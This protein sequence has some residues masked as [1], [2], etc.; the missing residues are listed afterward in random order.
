MVSGSV[1]AGMRINE[2][3]KENIKPEISFEANE[4]NKTIT[5]KVTHIRGIKN[6]TYRWN[7]EEAKEIETKN[8]NNATETINMLGGENTLSV[9]ATDENGK[10]QTLE[11]SYKVENIPEIESIES[12]DNGVKITI[13]SEEKLD[14]LQYSWDDG[15]MQKIEIGEK[16]YEGII[17][18]PKGKHTLKIEVV[19][20]KG[21]KADIVK[22][23]IGDTVP[24]V[25]VES[26]YIDG[27]PTFVIDAEDDESITT[28]SIIHNGGE[29][30]VINVNEK[31]FHKEVQ[32]TENQ[33]NTI[34]IT[35]TNK[36]GLEQTRRI[37]IKNN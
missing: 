18:A 8:R 17:N 27:K 4:E 24:T 5:I 32:M 25:N 20:I 15:A 3:V 23:V 6:I 13:K 37:R 21:M 1:Y 10:T 16:T 35:A 28:I 36:N 12:V 34:I 2:T 9:S 19:D 30:Q 31:T 11:K 7:D 14:Y 22:E 26:V 29:E 33:E